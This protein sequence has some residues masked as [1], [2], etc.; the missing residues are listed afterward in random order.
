MFLREHFPD[1]SIDAV[2]ISG[3]VIALARQWFG[4]RTAETDRR[5]HGRL[6]IVEADGR[7]FLAAAAMRRSAYDLGYDVIFLDAFAQGVPLPLRTIQ[8]FRLVS[9][10]LS[11]GGVLISNLDMSSSQGRMT[12]SKSRLIASIAAVFGRPVLREVDLGNSKV[13]FATKASD[14]RGRRGRMLDN[15]PDGGRTNTALSV[16]G[17]PTKAWGGTEGPDRT[18]LAAACDLLY[19]GLGVGDT[20]RLHFTRALCANNVARP[21]QDSEGP[22]KDTHA[23]MDESSE[24]FLRSTAT[25]ESR[26]NLQ[27]LL[28]QGVITKDEYDLMGQRA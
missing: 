23:A 26:C 20:V 15:R 28:E 4:L 18:K 8:F 17:G 1:A 11:P 24:T 7:T 5:G 9:R 19:P 3:T 27:R 2:E 14:R 10:A 25:A 16:H 6:R 22:N 13:I 12:P 21:Y